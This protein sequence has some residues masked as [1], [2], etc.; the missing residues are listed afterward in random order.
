MARFEDRGYWNRNAETVSFP[1]L[2]GA[3]E[4]DVAIVGG[5]ISG[6][7]AARLMKDKGLSVAVV[8]AQRVGRGATG[9]ST[10][11]VTSQHGLKYQ[12]LER[13]FGED[14]AR[15]YAEAQ[16][17]SLRKIALLVG[18]YG[19]ACDF[20]TA[21]AYVYTQDAAEVEGI[22]RE[23]ELARKLGLPAELT[24]ETDLPFD[25]LAA[26]RFDGQA[27]FHP[28]KY[29]AG[30]AETIPG[31]GC[32]VF[33]GSRV[34]D[35]TSTSV[36]TGQ[37]EVRARY[38]A[39]TTHMPLGQTGMYYAKAA[40]YAEPVIAARI[41][42]APADMYI[43]AEKPSRSI[44][45]HVNGDGE[46][47]AIAAGSGFK[48]GHPDEE[49]EAFA[50]LESWLS[51]SFGATAEYRWVN[52]DYT[53]IDEMPFAGWSSADDERYLVATGFDAWGITNGTAAATVMAELAAGD[54]DCPWF[55]VFDAHRLKPVAGGTKFMKENTEVAKHLAS[56]YLSRKLHSFDE[57]KPGEAAILKVDGK[58]VAAFRDE[59]GHLHSV[60][61]VCSHM[62][63]IVGWNETDRSWDCP[64]HGSRF[65]L[66]GEVI[67][68]PATAPLGKGVTG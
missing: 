50:E 7:T 8:E 40:P 41:G 28:T 32:H 2:Q 43:T 4:V 48:P 24:N 9:K 39:M 66:T 11:K 63:C 12:V 64:C 53:P 38:V 29:V 3:V 26:L 51:S 52:E 35:W 36:T 6:V 37:G 1:Q 33:E 55:D 18:E 44:R 65:D 49:R 17:A 25:V 46:T 67:H 59:E 22:E 14:R 20:E 56:G 30:L 68:G 45:A 15:L 62:G 16:Q 27:K 13:K 57:L 60:S 10:A 61:A 54:D 34:L 19:I 58:N 31:E 47:F 23:A 21:A 5:G 42:R